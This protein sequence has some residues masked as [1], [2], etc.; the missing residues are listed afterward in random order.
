MACRCGAVVEATACG[1]GPASAGT[2]DA[3]AGST[4]C[5]WGWSPCHSG[6]SESHAASHIGLR[7]AGGGG[8]DAARAAQCGAQVGMRQSRTLH[9]T[10]SAQ[11]M[12]RF[13]PTPYMDDRSN[14]CF[15]LLPNK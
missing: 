12:E 6:A 1:R 5:C 15:S 11:R 4:C 8:G 10:Y 3:A 13:C 9:D 14:T 2:G 7:P